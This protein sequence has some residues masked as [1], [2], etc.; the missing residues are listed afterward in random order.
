MGRIGEAARTAGRLRRPF[1]RQ[2]PGRNFQRYVAQH[3]RAVV[4]VSKRNAVELNIA[5]DRRQ[6]GFSS[7]W[8]GGLD[9]YVTEKIAVTAEATYVWVVGTKVK[10]L[11]YLSLGLGA[12]YRFY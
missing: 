3:F 10:D 2:L 1:P 5:P 9:V 7:R 4:A 8:G 6:F 12:I 11:S